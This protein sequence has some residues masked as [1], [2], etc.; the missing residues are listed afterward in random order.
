MR[1]LGSGLLG[2]LGMVVISGFYR[3]SSKFL[4]LVLL[5]LSREKGIY[6]LHNPY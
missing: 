5:V 3:L 6:S 2:E 1:V 4:F